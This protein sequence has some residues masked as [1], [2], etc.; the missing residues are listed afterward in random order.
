M[1]SKEVVSW[2]MFSSA[3]VGRANPNPRIFLHRREAWE[4]RQATYGRLGGW[5]SG[6]LDVCWFRG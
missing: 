6:R 2:V 5:R 4:V 3:G 1:N